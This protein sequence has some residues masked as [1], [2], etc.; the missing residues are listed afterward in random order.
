VISRSTALAMLATLCALAPSARAEEPAPSVLEF[1]TLTRGAKGVVRCGLFAEAGWL[2]KPVQSAVAP[3]VGGAALCVFKGI[4]KGVYGISA[5]HDEN[6]NGKLDTNILGMP[7]EDYC[8]SR[9]ARGTLGPPSFSDARF[10]YT[11]GS[12]RLEAHLK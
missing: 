6:V 7:T 12:K 9:E 11:G 4:P 8:A 2:K 1:R 10:K 5:F 3:I